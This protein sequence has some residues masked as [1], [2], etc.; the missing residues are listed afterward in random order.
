[1]CYTDNNA[2]DAGQPAKPLTASNLEKLLQQQQQ[3][4]ED[5]HTDDEEEGVESY[6]APPATTDERLE[7]ARIFL[8]DEDV[9]VNQGFARRHQEIDAY[10]RRISDEKIP[11]DAQVYRDVKNML[12]VHKMRM[13]KQRYEGNRPIDYNRLPKHSQ[14]LGLRDTS[15]RANFRGAPLREDRP[16]FTIERKPDQQDFL[17]AFRADTEQGRALRALEAAAY[18]ATLVDSS[19]VNEYLEERATA[20]ETEDDRTERFNIRATKRGRRRAAVQIA[21][22]SFARNCE[23][24]FAGGWDH[25][26][27]RLP[28]PPVEEPAEPIMF[29]PLDRE[30]QPRAI[31][32]YR[33]TRKMLQFHE[34]QQAIEEL[35]NVKAASSDTNLGYIWL[36]FPNPSHKH[37]VMRARYGSRIRALA[38]LSYDLLVKQAVQQISHGRSDESEHNNE[39]QAATFVEDWVIPECQELGSSDLPRRTRVRLILDFFTSDPRWPEG[40]LKT[41][42][43][44]ST[45]NAP[46]IAAL[47]EYMKSRSTVMNATVYGI[48]TRL[49]TELAYVWNRLKGNL[50]GKHKSRNRQIAID[51]L[52]SYRESRY[53]RDEER[54]KTR[55][56]RAPLRDLAQPL[57]GNEAELTHAQAINLMSDQILR[58]NHE[59]RRPKRVAL[60]EVWSFADHVPTGSRNRNFFSIE[61][62]SGF[63]HIGADGKARIT[64]AEKRKA[65][66]DDDDFLSSPPRKRQRARDVD[67]YLDHPVRRYNAVAYESLNP[68]NPNPSRRLPP[69]EI[70]FVQVEET[71]EGRAPEIGSGELMPPEIKDFD[72]LR[73][74]HVLENAPDMKEN[75]QEGPPY[76]PFA[77][78]PFM[79]VLLGRQVAN[80][81]A[82][83]TLEPLLYTGDDVI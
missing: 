47:Q 33:Y 14:R 30:Q 55:G 70:G 63:A 61:Q 45:L 24:H 10:L 67:D 66:I 44:S 56:G 2:G 25:R 43:A 80:D 64:A 7:Q 27:V 42:F 74:G 73:D 37:A 60:D 71:P 20:H 77:E 81:M 29:A 34:Q 18:D 6:V 9:N 51:S 75:H 36:D 17:R 19:L 79:Q 68:D 3:E 28:P 8:S 57:N 16:P 15:K 49:G 54:H 62:W 39:S 4:R 12:F 5:R 83:G 53:K 58:E 31:H 82:P 40:Y 11:C 59:N 38:L 1:M 78:T 22:R 41:R 21:L 13:E 35:I 32:P 65:G 46:A 23:Q 76:F 52:V 72:Y 48:S 26:V 50:V 69:E